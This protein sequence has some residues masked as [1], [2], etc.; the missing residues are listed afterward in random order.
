MQAIL[1]FIRPTAG[2]TH[3]DM[4][5]GS[6][7]ALPIE[8]RE[9]SLQ[10]A[11]AGD[12]DPGA[13]LRDRGFTA[14]P[15]AEGSGI[16]ADADD[17]R[18]RF[19]QAALDALLDFT[20]AEK[21]ILV[22]PALVQR[23]GAGDGSLKPVGVCHADYTAASAT[24][25]IAQLES[26]HGPGLLERRFAVYNLWWLASEPPQDWPLALCDASTVAAADV[27]V[28]SAQAYDRSG[29][30]RDFGE[31]ALFRYN[32]RQHWFWYPELRSD[33]LLVFA[34][35]DSDAANA[36]M[37]PHSAFSNPAC[38]SGT[39]TRRSIECRCFALW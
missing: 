31:I 25:R 16:D 2:P 20:G 23:R 4:T 35:F 11:A 24:A 15:F 13:S 26:K 37:V 14:M 21:M 27:T 9:V 29:E 39:G 10:D 36:S 38:P 8:R 5:L 30:P 28:G 19:A 22:A 18:E 12:R 3:L 33:Q 1:T 7:G 32:P 17:W 34:G 6:A